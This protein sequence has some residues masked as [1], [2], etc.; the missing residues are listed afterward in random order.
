MFLRAVPGENAPELMPECFNLHILI[1][2]R[3]MR[4]D[5][6][7]VF[8]FVRFV[9]ARAISMPRAGEKQG[10]AHRLGQ[11]VDQLAAV[12][13]EQRANATTLFHLCFSI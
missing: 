9:V 4:Q 8:S 7:Y 5:G 12:E 10:K 6:Q 13:F 1:V 3:R 11:N 2:L